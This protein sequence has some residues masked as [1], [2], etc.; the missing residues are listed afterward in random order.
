MLEPVQLYVPREYIGR[1]GGREDAE[2]AFVAA[3]GQD[4]YDDLR[5]ETQ[6]QAGGWWLVGQLE[7]VV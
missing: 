3:G 5:L 7:H 2:S 1:Q 4:E 6:C